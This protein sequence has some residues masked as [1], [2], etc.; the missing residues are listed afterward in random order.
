MRTWLADPLRNRY[1][2]TGTRV[3][4]TRIFEWFEKDFAR[5][6]GSVQAWIAR[7]APAAHAGWIAQAKH[8]K[9]EYLEYS[10][11]LNDAS[12]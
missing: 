7:Y 12:R 2:R 8:L 4:V 9:I 3:L 1:D 6:A 5:D 10:W 11:K